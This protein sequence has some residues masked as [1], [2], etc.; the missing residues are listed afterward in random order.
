MTDLA[1][2]EED[3]SERWV[4]ILYDDQGTPIYLSRDEWEE[5]H[6]ADPEDQG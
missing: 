6:R 2:L 4:Y 1:L 3:P 5:V